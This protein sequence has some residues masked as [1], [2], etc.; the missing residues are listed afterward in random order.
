MS[1]S[2][3]RPFTVILQTLQSITFEKLWWVHFRILIVI[4]SSGKARN[5]VELGQNYDRKFTCDIIYK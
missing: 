1:M 2:E 3:L 5:F 4:S